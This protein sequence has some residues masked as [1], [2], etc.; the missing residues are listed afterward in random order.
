MPRIQRVEGLADPQP[1]SPAVYSDRGSEASGFYLGGSVTPQ[2][3]PPDPLADLDLGELSE[4]ER[5]QRELDQRTEMLEDH[6]VRVTLYDGTIVV[7]RD[8]K[9]SDLKA[10]EKMG[11]MGNIEKTMR[12]I[13]KLCTKWGNQP[14]ITVAELDNVR[15]KDLTLLGQVLGKFL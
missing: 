11:N 3:D 14:G 15:A 5:Q 2:T 10:I 1:P 9:G 13:A 12:L 4:Q 8:M 7:L 6:S